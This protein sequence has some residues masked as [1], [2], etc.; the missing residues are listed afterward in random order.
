MSGMAMVPCHSRRKEIEE[1]D[2]AGKVPGQ[3]CAADHSRVRQLDLQRSEV[4]TKL[5]AREG[6]AGVGTLAA[7]TS[8]TYTHSARLDLFS[9]THE[10]H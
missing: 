10:F 7:L 6:L 2:G 8:S 3:T 1:A 5:A 4:R 9:H